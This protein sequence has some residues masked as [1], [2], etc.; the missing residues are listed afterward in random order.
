M[1]ILNY[2]QIYLGIGLVLMILLDLMQR[3]VEKM[4]DENEFKELKWN[5]NERIYMVLMWPFIV[6]GL[7]EILIKSNSNDSEE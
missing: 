3:N 2:I 7:I 6:I 1:N 4:V 5:N